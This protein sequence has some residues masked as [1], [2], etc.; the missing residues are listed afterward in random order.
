LTPRRRS[1]LFRLAT[2]VLAAAILAATAASASARPDWWL[3]GSLAVAGLLALRFPVYLSLSHKVSV[4]A[5]VFFAAALLLP[6]WQA[7][8]LVAASLA[9]DSAV[10]ALIKIR[11]TREKPP[12]GAIGLSLLFNAGQGYLSVLAAGLVLA[13]AGVNA[14]SGLE[15]PSDA[16]A[17]VAA[18]AAMYATN[19]LLM[20]VAAAL[21]TSRNPWA[22]S[23]TTHKMVSAQF[24]SLY[25]VG[26]AAAFASVR[27]WWV[28]ILGTLPA[29]LAYLS[30]RNRVE[31]RREAVRAMER[32]AEEVDRRDP[33]T[34]QH[35]QRVAEYARSIARQL[36]LSAAEIELVELAAKVH[37]IGK[38]RIPDTILLKPGRLTDDE[39]RVMETHPRLGFEILRQ[40]SEY[41][42]VLD[43]VLSHH[44]RYDGRGYP[45]GTVGRRLLLIA[46]VIPVA[47]SLDAMTS[48]RAYRGARTW[49]WAMAELRRGAGS[50]WNPGV[51]EAAVAALAPAFEE[52][53]RE[54]R[55]AVASA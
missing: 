3:L 41:A 32:L 53:G 24:A 5:A 23:R 25:I 20:S 46:Q 29:V 36:R 14:Y 1:E 38:I 11:A 42:K 2:G 27:F 30:M 45:N 34:Y 43:L 35:S 18:G 12:W 9:L 28:P 51:V 19:F 16:L 7:G 13:G 48:G 26:A 4:A 6:A 15:R 31:L 22:I 55:T 44:E 54:L 37:D 40:F 52:A 21:A 47:D 39:R 49:D 33:Y 8:A 17:I 50:Q 10:A